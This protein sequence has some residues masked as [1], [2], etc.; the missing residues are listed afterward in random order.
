[1]ALDRI[2]RWDN[3]KDLPS[4]GNMRQFISN[5]FNSAAK[6]EWRIDRF[7][8]TLPGSTSHPMEGMSQSSLVLCYPEFRSERWIE[9]C[10]M[11]SCVYVITRQM[12]PYTN[13]LAQRLYEEIKCW[14]GGK[15]DQ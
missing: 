1:M 11:E 13:G 9:V 14:F 4:K 3:V 7:Y 2:V 10:L 15:I 8:V 12:D 5:F 6:V